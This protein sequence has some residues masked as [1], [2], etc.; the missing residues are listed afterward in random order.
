[1]VDEGKDWMVT[2][3]CVIPQYSLKRKHGLFDTFSIHRIKNISLEYGSTLKFHSLKK[4]QHFLWRKCLNFEKIPKQQQKKFKFSVRCDGVSASLHMEQPNRANNTVPSV[5]EVDADD[6]EYDDYDEVDDG[7]YDF[8][9]TSSDEDDDYD[10]ENVDIRNIRNN[11][12]AGRYKRKIGLD[13]GGTKMF[14][15]VRCEQEN[16]I[17]IETNF[18]LSAKGYHK[19]ARY[20]DSKKRRKKSPNIA[21]DIKNHNVVKLKYAQENSR[22][23][24]V[25]I[26]KSMR[27]I[28]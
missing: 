8:N 5:D 28:Y 14:T 12:A 13:F 1:M 27:S 18:E 3:F 17:W 16:G 21:M 26:I 4:D 9:V 20:V 24:K 22:H 2:N 25:M 11:F 6:S 19:L 23:E 10:G 7:D 15:G